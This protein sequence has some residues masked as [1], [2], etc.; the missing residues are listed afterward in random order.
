MAPYVLPVILQ[1]C[2][3]YVMKL[4]LQM[5][6]SQ[7][8]PILP[9]SLSYLVLPPVKLYCWWLPSILIDLKRQHSFWLWRAQWSYPE[10]VSHM[11]CHASITQFSHEPI[12]PAFTPLFPYFM[13]RIWPMALPRTP[14]FNPSSWVLFSILFCVILFSDIIDPTLTVAPNSEMGHFPLT[15]FGLPLWVPLSSFFFLYPVTISSY[16]SNA[17]VPLGMLQLFRYTVMRLLSGVNFSLIFILSFPLYLYGIVFPVCASRYVMKLFL[18]LSKRHALYLIISHYKI[19]ILPA[20]LPIIFKISCHGKP[21]KLLSTMVGILKIF[22]NLLH[23]HLTQVK[24]PPGCS[25]G[26]IYLQQIRREH[27]SNILSWD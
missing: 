23:R 19:I 7:N 11:A 18:H 13:T 4:F 5:V 3:S 15:L 16:R 2:K 17:D 10:K 12:S 6:G 22:E 8:C 14:M 25:F 27:C 21:T 26:H 20:M 9:L 1:H 24:C